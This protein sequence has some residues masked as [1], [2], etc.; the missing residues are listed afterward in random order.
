[1]GPLGGY[2]DGKPAAVAVWPG[3]W[4][5]RS[6][7]MLRLDLAEATTAMRK[8][9]KDSEGIPYVVDG[10]NGPEYADFHSLRHSFITNVVESGVSPK[11]A[12]EL[13][14]YSTVTLTLRLYAHVHLHDKNAAVERL[15]NLLPSTPRTEQMRATR[16][17]GDAPRRCTPRCTNVAPTA[18]SE[19]DELTLVEAQE[20]ERASP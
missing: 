5:E 9:D 19:G 11:M 14:R 6:A 16:T 7:K 12:Q 10:S 2:L 15:P 13:A 1:M 20:G 8:I 4:H 3:T 17:A 18:D